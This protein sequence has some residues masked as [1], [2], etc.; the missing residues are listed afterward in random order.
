MSA[1]PSFPGFGSA[2]SGLGIELAVT[3][4]ELLVRYAALLRDWNTRI[5]LVS[6]RDTERVMTYHVIDSLAVQRLL[7]PGARVCD[8]GTG[9]GL[10]GIPLAI[11]RPDLEMLLVESSQKRVMFLNAAVAELEVSN[12]RVIGCRAESLAPLDCSVVLSRL[13]G[14]LR[15]LLKHAARHRKP[16]GKVVLYKTR[17]SSAEVDKLAPRYRLRVIETVDL[18]LPLTDTPRRFIVLGA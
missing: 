6:R 9:A 17:E 8:V 13:S 2:C 18:I 16:D 12:C 15:D 14:P 10:P 11:V 3:Q 5:N 4:Y 1:D 7:P